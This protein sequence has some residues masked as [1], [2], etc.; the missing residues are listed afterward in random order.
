MALLPRLTDEEPAGG[1]ETCP[2]SR[3]RKQH[4]WD[5]SPM[6]LLHR[7]LSWR[8]Q[9][10]P[11]APEAPSVVIDSCGQWEH[12][13]RSAGQDSP[14]LSP[15]RLHRWLPAL[16]VFVLRVVTVASGAVSSQEV[17][18]APECWAWLPPPPGP[19]VAPGPPHTAR[20]IWSSSPEGSQPLSL[21]LP[22]V[23]AMD[24]EP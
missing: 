1:S 9:P 14:W 15:G 18:A 24:P 3:A 17:L 7:P 5:L 8:P 21:T 2:R 16:C 23:R 10:P 20:G 4:T 19:R 13:V 22:H 12:S 6:V 11:P